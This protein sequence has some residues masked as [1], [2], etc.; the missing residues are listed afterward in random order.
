MKNKFRIE[1]DSLSEKEIPVSSLYGI[2]T[3]RAIENF[4]VSGITF[5][6]SFIKSYVQIKLAA[7]IA[8]KKLKVIDSKKAD[9]I[10]QVCKEI[11]EGKHKDHFVIDVFQ[12]G[13]G[14]NLNM[15][16]NEV[17]ANRALE[18]LKKQKGDYS[19]LSPN[20][21]VN[22]SQSTNDTFPTAMYLSSFEKWQELK[23]I[24]N[25]L[26]NSFEKKGNEFN[27]IIKA[28]RTHL[29]DAVPMR[30]GREFLA[31]SDTIKRSIRICDNVSKELLELP[32][33][34]TAIGTGLNAPFGYK[35]IVIDELKKI[36]GFSLKSNKNLFEGIQSIQPVSIMSGALKSFSLELTRIAN[37]L[38]L[39][40][41]GPNTGFNE[42]NLPS[43]QSGS[44][45]MP[46]K[47]NPSLIECLNMICFQII[48]NDTVVSYATQA[49]QLELNIMMPVIAYNLLQSFKLLINFLPIFTKKCING[50][51]ANNENCLKYANS[52]TA[53]GTVLNPKIGYLNAA[54]II[55][56]SIKTNKSV[57]DL[58]VDKKILTFEEAKKIFD[59]EKLAG[60]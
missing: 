36:T 8:N 14:T 38:R 6:Y 18:I 41:S 10:I 56:E 50:I 11:L 13:A 15:N 34:G 17:I 57:Y 42:I 58:L 32:I 48:G 5:E 55:N 3:Q 47:V 2:Q 46:A 43:V 51:T 30:L 26:S 28:G 52:T 44:S 1:K 4:K 22:C 12:A 16:I 35:E 27:K 33:G 23:V 59:L 31:Y 19:F 45:I 7:C 25:E 21:H 40:S 39:L 60:K 37:D 20:D 9:A 53:L 24:L 29:R 49:G 54:K